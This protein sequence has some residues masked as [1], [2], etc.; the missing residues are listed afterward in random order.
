MTLPIR[1]RD[2]AQQ[3]IKNAAHWY[4]NQLSCLGQH[5]LDEV[6]NGLERITKHPYLYPQVLGEIR[7][8]LIRRFPFGIFYRVESTQIVII[9]VMHSSRR[10]QL[11][12]NRT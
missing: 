6:L 12:S 10:P 9:A 4:E 2:E 1:I 7:R 5:F 8:I 3:D 11:W